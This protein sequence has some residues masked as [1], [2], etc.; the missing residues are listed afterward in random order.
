MVDANECKD[1]RKEKKTYL[2]WRWSLTRV[3]VVSGWCWMRMSREKKEKKRKN[4]LLT[5]ELAFD[6]DGIGYGW[7]GRRWYWTQMVLD[8]EGG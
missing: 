7:Y 4:L 6:A 8:A 5:V 3:D 2:W 1:K